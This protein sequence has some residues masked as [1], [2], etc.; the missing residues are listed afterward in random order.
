MTA[1]LI[2]ILLT[3]APGDDA[4]DAVPPSAQKLLDAMDAQREQ[5]VERLMAKTKSDKRRGRE[6]NE[7]ADFLPAIFQWDD[8]GWE[9]DAGSVSLVPCGIIQTGMVEGSLPARQV[10]LA[11]TAV[12]ER[13]DA[14]AIVVEVGFVKTFPAYQTG[15]LDIEGRRKSGQ[16]YPAREFQI[17]KTVRIEDIDTSKY[18]AGDD[19]E[20]AQVFERVENK[21][22]TVVLRPFDLA[23][24]KEWRQHHKPTKSKP[25]WKPK[26]LKRTRR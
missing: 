20:S 23:A 17:T 21:S 22:G 7:G 14:Q 8:N 25:K 19:F 2:V 16:N 15:T 6:I 9:K 13:V 12:V 11:V 4:A 18:A 5:T 24:F 10:E 26:P 3:A 1:L